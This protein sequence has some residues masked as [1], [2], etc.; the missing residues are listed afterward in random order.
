MRTL[1]DL[2]LASQNAENTDEVWLVLLTIDHANILDGPLRFVNDMG[3]LVVLPTNLNTSATDILGWSPFGV[4]ST[5]Q[6]GSHHYR[7]TDSDPASQS[8]VQ[9]GAVFGLTNGVTYTHCIRVKKDDIGKATRY[10]SFAASDLVSNTSRINVDTN[11]GEFSVAA[12]NP[13]HVDAGVVDAGDSWLVYISRNGG[14]GSLLTFYPAW[15][16]HPSSLAGGSI[17]ATGSAVVS[18]PYLFQGVIADRVDYI[19]FPFQIDLPGE[20]P[21]VPSVARLKIDNVDQQI[22]E[23]IRG[24]P[25]APTASL[26]VVL[27]SQ[28]EEVEIGFYDLTIRAADFDALYVEAQM[29]FEPI[30][31]EPLSVEMTPARFPGLF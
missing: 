24:L 28:P 15:G 10:V 1:S 27:H 17:A 23:A 3:N 6:L 22:V 20:D 21:E 13:G 14:T 4:V 19:A 30:F 5:A 7:V 26:E 29:T 9:G 8:G 18:R 31:S 25:S 16:A 12:G 2:A 11:T